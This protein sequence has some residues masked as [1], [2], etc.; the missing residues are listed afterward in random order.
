M[1]MSQGDRLAT[2]LGYDPQRLYQH[3]HN[4]R[5]TREEALIR[6]I[7]MY[8]LRWCC[9]YT[10]RESA[11]VFDMDASSCAYWCRMVKDYISINDSVVIQYLRYTQP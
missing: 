5:L 1:I 9:R 3:P 10:M 6:G 11:E 2:T 4:S 8:Q 7:M